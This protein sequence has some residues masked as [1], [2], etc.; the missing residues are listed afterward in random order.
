MTS[1]QKILVVDDTGANLV[2]MGRVLEGLD[3]EIVCVHSG[4]EAL[5]ATLHHDFAAAVIDVQ[6]PEMDGYELAEIL[7]SDERTRALPIRCVSA[8]YSEDAHVFRGY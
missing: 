1:I 4:N 5:T 8:V 3:V 7:R 6:M 2:A